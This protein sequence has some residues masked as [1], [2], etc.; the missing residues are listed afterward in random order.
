[1]S[2]RAVT[3]RWSLLIGVVALLV[4]GRAHAL[5]PCNVDTDC[6]GAACGGE[7]CIKSSGLSMC[8]PAHTQGASGINDGRCDVDG[9]E[10]N[11]NCKCASLGATCVGF[12]CTFTIPPGTGTGGGGGGS[13]GTGGSGTGTGGS[14]TGSAG[15]GGGGDGG[16]SVAGASSFGCAAGV[17][18]LAAALLR[19]RV[20]PRA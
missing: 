16:C 13:T 19:R 17:M 11:S 9:V 12:F 3:V 20:R 8:Y 10:V 7:V 4:A 6:P 14:G 1:M 15:T 2:A 5:P 18:L